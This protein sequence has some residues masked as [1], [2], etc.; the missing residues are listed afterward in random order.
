MKVVFVTGNHLRHFFLADRLARAGVLAGLVIEE[1][2]PSTPLPPDGLGVRTARLFIRHF[3]DRQVAEQR[4]LGAHAAPTEARASTLRVSP[5][6]LNGPAVH[7]LIDKVCPDVLLSF[8]CHKLSPATLARVPGRCW[9]IHGGL[10]PWYRGA[11]THFW[12]SYMLEPQMT[13][14]TVHVTTDAIDGGDVI[15][16]VAAPLV[17]GDGIHDLSCRAVAALADQ[18]PEL[19][20]V[21]ETVVAR[22]HR[23]TG[24]IWRSVD[25]RPAHL[26]MIYDLYENRVVDQFLDGN[27]GGRPPVIFDGLETVSSMRS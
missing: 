15:H 14:M 4:L 17:R 24:R 8:G 20:A 9:N 27:L 6:D 12:P 21:A 13:G 18:L 26:H 23:T 5:K 22:E 16:Q 7:A 2:E 11:I 19:L 10:T 3:A 1:R 25:W